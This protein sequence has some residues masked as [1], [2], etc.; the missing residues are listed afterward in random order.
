MRRTKS[1]LS[2]ML[3][4]C[5]GVSAIPV[6]AQDRTATPVSVDA[7][8][9]LTQELLA[10]NTNPDFLRAAKEQPPFPAQVFKTVGALFGSAQA[11]PQPSAPASSKPSVG[12][13]IL[14]GTAVGGGIGLVLGALVDHKATCVD[15]SRGIVSGHCEG[16]YAMAFFGGD[17]AA[18]GA[19]IG[20]LVH[21]QRH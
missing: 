16:H 15:P 11:Y 12:R 20:F 5:M 6:S 18:L 4:I 17:G 9:P 14:I 13:D 3:I 19:L 10:R 21:R 2:S 1:A 7:E 8:R